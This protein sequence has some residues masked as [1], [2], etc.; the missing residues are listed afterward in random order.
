MYLKWKD[1]L[2]PDIHTLDN[3]RVIVRVDF[4]MP[5]VDGV[6]TDTSRFDVVVPFLK[7]LAF[8][9]AK[10]IIL[11]HFGEQK[12]SLSAIAKHVTETLN[13]ITFNQSTNFD[14]LEKMSHAL[15]RGQGILLENVNIFDGEAENSLYTGRAYSNLG[16]VFINNAF[17]VSH[18]KCASVVGIANSML[19]YFGPTFV[20]ELENLTPAFTPP[21][22]AL[23]ILG[24]TKITTKR[25]LVQHYLEL[26]VDVFVGGAMAHAIWKAR[27]VEIGKSFYNEQEQFPE[28]FINHPL[29]VTPKD[30]VLATGE[31]VPFNKIPADATVV[32]CGNETLI[33]LEETIAHS[34]TVIASGSLGI[35]EQGWRHGSEHILSKL[36]HT[37]ATT[38]IGGD[39]TVTLAHSLGVLQHF[40]FVSFGGRAMLEFLASGTL[41]G[42]DAVTK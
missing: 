38:Y 22:P 25:Y 23:L 14:E 42:I 13:F 16:D 39:E 33:M 29:L 35:C 32:D 28:S 24:G 36:A 40:N 10:I 7:E 20:R 37:Q 4:D 41:V 31:T 12:E 9:G 2:T 11:T 1:H 17:S 19:S 3:K 8:A 18:K 26:G 5:I 34:K 30:V 21:K 15:G 6:I 27:G